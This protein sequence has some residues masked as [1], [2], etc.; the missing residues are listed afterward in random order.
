MKDESAV[1]KAVD[2]LTEAGEMSINLP[3][4]PG[5]K[6]G[7]DFQTMDF[8]EAQAHLEKLLGVKA[9][10]YGTGGGWSGIMFEIDGQEIGFDM[11][12]NEDYEEGGDEPEFINLVY[13]DD[14]TGFKP[15]VKNLI[16]KKLF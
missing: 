14:R 2:T 12:E 9:L 1:K 3:V 13:T 6:L 16:I 5:T 8:D 4:G 11:E 10:G 7:P 15:S